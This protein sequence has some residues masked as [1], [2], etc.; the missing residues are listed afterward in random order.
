MAEWQR[1]RLKQ[2]GAARADQLMARSAGRGKDSS[3]CYMPGT[4]F[5]KVWLHPQLVR[6]VDGKV[7]QTVIDHFFP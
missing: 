1:H 5:L 4:A 7:Q 2:D 3:K 6:D